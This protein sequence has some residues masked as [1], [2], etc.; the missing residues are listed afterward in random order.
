MH[1]GGLADGAVTA[2]LA[3]AGGR[4]VTRVRVAVGP[5]VDIEAVRA[6]WEH[7]VEGTPLAAAAVEWSAATDDLTCWE[8]GDDY[9][10]T[11]LTRCPACGSTGLVVAPAPELAVEDWG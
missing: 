6:R 4:P 1:E 9:R 5:A 10:G 7:A 2:L 11:R 3:A 8:C